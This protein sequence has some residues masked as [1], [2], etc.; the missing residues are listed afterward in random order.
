MTGEAAMNAAIKERKIVLVF[1]LVGIWFWNLERG[2]LS[3]IIIVFGRMNDDD[4]IVTTRTVL[5]FTLERFSKT[6]D[7]SMNTVK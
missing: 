1:I 5:Y 3:V 2:W 4:D 6:F 7:Y